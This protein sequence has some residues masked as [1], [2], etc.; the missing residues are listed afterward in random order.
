MNKGMLGG[1]R[2]VFSFTLKQAAG[3][4]YRGVTV[5]VA[6]VMLVAGLAISTVMAFVQKQ[7]NDKRSPIRQVYVLSLIHI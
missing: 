7:E 4:K 3:K 5:G 1:W 2:D 6:L